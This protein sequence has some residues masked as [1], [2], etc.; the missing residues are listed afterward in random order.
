M[1]GVVLKCTKSLSNMITRDNLNKIQLHTERGDSIILNDTDPFLYI[2]KKQ[3]N[4]LTIEK[5]D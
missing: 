3:Q 4:L 1:Y 2:I 5:I